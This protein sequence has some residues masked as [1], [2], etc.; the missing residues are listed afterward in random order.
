[1]KAD[2]RYIGPDKPMDHEKAFFPKYEEYEVL[3]GED[4][5]QKE[6]R[7]KDFKN[8]YLNTDEE[9]FT[10]KKEEKPK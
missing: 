5:S 10:K 3:P 8:P 9:F 4:K 2:G 6:D 7:W 1:M